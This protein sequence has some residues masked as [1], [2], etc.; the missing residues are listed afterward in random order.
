MFDTIIIGGGIVGCT[1]ARELSKYN[2]KTLLVEMGE[3]IASGISKANSGIIHSGVHQ[4]VGSLKAKLNIE[5]NLMY[6]LLSKELDF[7]LIRN[8]AFILAF[9]EDEYEALKVLHENGQAMGIPGLKL[10]TK[11]EVREIE[12]NIA[13]D[14]YGALQTK[15]SAIISPYD[16]T[17]AF[18]E[19]AAE[20][21][22]EFKFHTKITKIEKTEQ[23][24]YR[25]ESED[26]SL[27]E[28]KA[29]INAAGLYSDELYNQLHENRI[30]ITPIKGEYCLF[31]KVVGQM[32][33]STVFQVP[34]QVSKGILVTP[35][36]DGNLLVGPNAIK[37]EDKQDYTTHREELDTLLQQGMKSIPKIPMAGMLTNFA[38]LRPHVEEGDFIIED[39]KEN[40]GVIHLVGIDSP[41]LTAAPAIAVNVA[42]MLGEYLP[43]NLKADF[44]PNRKGA[45]RFA[46][47]S[48]EEK[49]RLIQEN[50]AYGKI[51]CKC[52]G[53]TE[54]EILDAI[55]RPLGATSVDGV[56]R[57]TRA[58]MGGCQGTG[59]L[60]PISKIICRELGIHM[61]DLMKNAKESNAIGYKGVE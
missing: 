30:H 60:F 39:D 42:K 56:K 34:T 16:T 49:N 13:S 35:T 26:G 12:P 27:F 52:E 40:P 18:A 54:G 59:C 57:R 19:N 24:Y 3:D 33:K 17:L 22:V 44:Q 48:L 55:H 58:T 46:E 31:T 29:V 8:G 14:I 4:K 50:P 25:L 21:G 41:G 38:G 51:V 6:D 23:G 53:I 15:T 36:V 32:V 43:L 20:N 2:L 47:L 1:I 11:E 28:S 37:V 61:S 9:N 7:T 45:I 10:L 5:G